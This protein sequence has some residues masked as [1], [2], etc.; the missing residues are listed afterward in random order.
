MVT[1]GI[2]DETVAGGCDANGAVVVPRLVPL[3]GG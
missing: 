2:V 1:V 3:A